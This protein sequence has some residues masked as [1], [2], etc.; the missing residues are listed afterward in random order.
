MENPRR[1]P[2]TTGRRTA[3]TPPRGVVSCPAVPWFV[4]SSRCCPKHVSALSEPS[5]YMGLDKKTVRSICPHCP[6][7]SQSA[8][9]FSRGGQQ[10][11]VRFRANRNYNATALKNLAL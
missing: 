11:F 5:N 6:P 7:A 4:S 2:D 10:L 1:T 3:R 9:F 8:K